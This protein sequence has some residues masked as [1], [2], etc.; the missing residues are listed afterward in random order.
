MP[1]QWHQESQPGS[2]DDTSNV[3]EK[4]LIGLKCRFVTSEL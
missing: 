4:A 1:F 3:E 2:D